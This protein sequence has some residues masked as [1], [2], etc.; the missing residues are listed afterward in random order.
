M[1][2]GYPEKEVKKAAQKAFKLNRQS[3]LA[4]KGP[5]NKTNKRNLDRV[6][7]I[8]TYNPAN[9]NIGAIITKHWKLLDL[10]KKCKE[11]F[12]KKPIIAYR[13]NKNISDHL[14]RAKCLFPDT[15]QHPRTATCKKPWQCLFCPNP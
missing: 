12:T 11:I 5:S 10:S 8:V 13:R 3:L 9:P 2:R 6:P 4:P 7:L 1:R 15:T 14:V